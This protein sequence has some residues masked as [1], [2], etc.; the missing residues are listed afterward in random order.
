[1]KALTDRPRH[2]PVIDHGWYAQLLHRLDR[3]TARA[4]RHHRARAARRYTTRAAARPGQW[5]PVLSLRERDI[6]TEA[7]SG[8]LPAGIRERVSDVFVPDADEGVVYVFTE[9]D[10]GE[11]HLRLPASDWVRLADPAPK[12]CVPGGY[13]FASPV[14]SLGGRAR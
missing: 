6:I 12:Q 8:Q 7:A 3:A 14:T 13:V 1:M 10:A 2:N 9:P 11:A 5:V 4:R